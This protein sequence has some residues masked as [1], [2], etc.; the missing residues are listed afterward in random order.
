M[1][2]VHVHVQVQIMPPELGFLLNASHKHSVH[3]GTV[4]L[5][6]TSK[7]AAVD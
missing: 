5:L 6:F 3:V 7:L 4:V 2:S 1:Q